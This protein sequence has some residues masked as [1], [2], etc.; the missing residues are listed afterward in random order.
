MGGYSGLDVRDT[1][2]QMYGD[3]VILLYRIQ[4][5]RFTGYSGPDEL[6]TMVQMYGIQWSR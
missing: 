1:V 5:F 2:V 4:W 6:D 3:T